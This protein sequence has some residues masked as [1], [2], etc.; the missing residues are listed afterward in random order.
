MKKW[1]QTLYT[2]KFCDKNSIKLSSDA[3]SNF[4]RSLFH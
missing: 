2:L 3:T 4:L 1:F